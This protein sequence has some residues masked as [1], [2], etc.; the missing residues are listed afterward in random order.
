MGYPRS[1]FMK[2]DKKT[3]FPTTNKKNRFIL[4]IPLLILFLGQS[5]WHAKTKSATYDEVGHLTV[6][7]LLAKTDHSD[8]DIGHPPLVRHILALPLLWMDLLLPSQMPIPEIPPSVPL[9]ERPGSAIYYYGTY[10]LYANRVPADQILFASR[11]INI[12]LGCLLCFFVFKLSQRLYGNSAG[13][14]SLGLAALCP[15]LI[16]HSSLVTTD[17]GGITFAAGFLY[18]FIRLIDSNQQ[19]KW[20]MLTGLFLGL[21]LLSKFT[22]IFLV[23]LFILYFFYKGTNSKGNYFKILKVNLTV[24]FLGWFVLCYGYKFKNVFVP[25]TLQEVDWKNLGYGQTMQKIYRSVPLPDSFLRGLC[26][27]IYHD[28]RGH[29]AYLFGNYSNSG[30]WYYFPTAF[31]LKTPTVILFLL[32]GWLILIFKNQLRLTKFEVLLIAPMVFVLGSSMRA[33]LNIGLRHIILCYPLIY[34]LLGKVTASLLDEKFK[35]Q[36]KILIELIFLFL[37]V[38]VFSVF[39]HYLAFFNRMAGGPEKGIRY[40]SDSNIDWGQDLNGLAKFLKKEA[41]VEVL[42]SY[43]GTAV[44]QYYGIRYQALPTV[45]SFPKSEYINSILPQKEYLAVSVTNLQG[46]YFSQHDLYDWLNQKIPIKKIGYSIYVY[47]VSN[48]LESQQKLL[49][50]Y[51]MTGEATKILRQIERIKKLQKQGQNT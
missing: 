33:H 13:L 40:L 11:I 36:G 12:S 30:W 23:I 10:F 19:F 51:Q 16:A 24:L 35:K 18:M 21:A 38:E 47:D 3:D 32:S 43:F 22:N 49:E 15:T 46:T 7:Y 45:W 48:D 26:F 8:Y 6:S 20:T 37:A 39:P 5:V 25:H 44:P 28:K 50:I 4:T 27:A 29:G 17:I 34:V 31:L 41:G 1:I 42:L 14:F 2:Q 9:H